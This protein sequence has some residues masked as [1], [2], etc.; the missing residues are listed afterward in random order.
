MK[1]VKL[2]AKLLAVFILGVG[3]LMMFLNAYISSSHFDPLKDLKDHIQKNMDEDQKQLGVQCVDG[4]KLLS[5]YIDKVKSSLNEIDKGMRLTG[6]ESIILL[7]EQVS[8]VSVMCNGY[9]KSLEQFVP[10]TLSSVAIAEDATVQE[11]AV[12]RLSVSQTIPKW[13]HADC[14][15]DARKKIVENIA[16]LENRMNSN[17]S[18]INVGVH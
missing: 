10:H 4:D 15:Q 18:R 16:L 14:I 5:D 9:K 1:F 3:V 6:A 2:I 11:I 17:K 13:C 12:V 7:G 8:H